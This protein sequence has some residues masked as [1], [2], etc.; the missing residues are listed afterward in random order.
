M[1]DYE[2]RA[3]NRFSLEYG[4][5]QYF[6][7]WLEV[8]VMNGH[9]WQISDDS[10]SDAWWDGTRF[11]SRDKKS[12]FGVGV[13]VW[14]LEGMLSLRLKYIMDYAIKQRFKNQF[15]SFSLLLIPALHGK[16]SEE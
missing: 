12:T 8:E 9:N 15:V 1:R 14:T 13:G 7:E 5:S 4:I 6:T 16:E 2:E 10:G 11:D 3:G